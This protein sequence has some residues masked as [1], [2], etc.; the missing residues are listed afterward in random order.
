MT[1]SS[2]VQ[3]GSCKDIALFKDKILVLLSYENKISGKEG[4][5]LLNTMKLLFSPCNTD[6]FRI[7]VHHYTLKDLLDKTKNMKKSSESQISFKSYIDVETKPST[8]T[9]SG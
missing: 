9:I 8:S 3:Q 4:V 1:Q 7:L 2:K 5:S 6:E